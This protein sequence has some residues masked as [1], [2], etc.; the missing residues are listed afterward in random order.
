M[1]FSDRPFPYG[2]F[3]PHWVPKQYVESYFSLHRT[4][5]CLV[6]NTTVE[7]VSRVSAKDCNDHGR[8]K[9]ILRRNE[10]TRRVDIWW[11]EEFDAVILANGHYTVPFVCSLVSVFASSSTSLFWTVIRECADVLIPKRYL[12]STAWMNTYV[13]FQNESLI[14]KLTAQTA[15]TPTSGCF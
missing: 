11:E 15:Y 9:L 10:P 4:D 5:S 2:P 14:P 12:S 1:A 7:D 8:W 3:V 6:L 13:A